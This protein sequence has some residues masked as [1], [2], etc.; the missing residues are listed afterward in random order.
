MKL[1]ISDTQT[2]THRLVRL[3]AEQHSDY[4]YLGDFSDE[5]LKTFFLD[6]QPGMDVDKNR[7]LLKYFG[8]LH[9]FIVPKKKVSQN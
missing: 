2:P 5:E 9:L 3:N 1:W 7:E 8:Y 6:V 4:V